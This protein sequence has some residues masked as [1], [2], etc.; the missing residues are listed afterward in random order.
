MHR[1]SSKRIMQPQQ[2]R[3]V[4]KPHDKYFIVI[5]VGNSDRRGDAGASTFEVN[6]LSHQTKKSR[7][8][9]PMHVYEVRPRKDRRGVDLVSEVLPFGQLRYG[10]PGAVTNAIGYAEHRSRSRDAVF[11]VDDAQTT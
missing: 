11:R 3:C 1:S 7:K 4:A 2:L 6:L 9:P 10:G 8:M 5:V